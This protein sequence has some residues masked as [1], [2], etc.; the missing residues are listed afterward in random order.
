MMN[1]HQLAGVFGILGNIISFMVFLAPL[2]TFHTIY[3]RKSSEGFHFLPYSVALFSCMIT[4]Y[5]ALVKQHVLFLITINGIGIF[6]ETI[7]LVLYFVYAK[8]RGRILM[9]V[10]V[11]VFNIGVLGLIVV[12]TYFLSEGNKRVKIVGWIL[13]VISVCVFAAPLSIMMKVIRTKSVEYMPFNLS[14]F[15][16]LCAVVWL[17]YGLCIR[18]FYIATPNVLGFACGIVQLIL[19]A[20]YRDRKT[21]AVVAPNG[22]IQG[23]AIVV[24][25]TAAEMLQKGTDD[26]I[27]ETTPS[28]VVVDM[29]KVVEMQQGK[30]V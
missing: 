18:D 9:A 3:K 8:K 5:Y 13:S 7:Y 2:P 17:L 30:V 25:A 20:I 26:E 16:T 11:L 1:S 22:G 23:V 19:Y 24:D 4:L 12:L 27:H 29:K 28:S 15:L 6:V 21:A 10:A 14:L